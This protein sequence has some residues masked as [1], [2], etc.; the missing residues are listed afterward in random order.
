MFAEQCGELVRYL[1]TLAMDRGAS[2][3]SFVNPVTLSNLYELL[4]FWQDHYLNKD[5][6]CTALEQV[7]SQFMQF[8]LNGPLLMLFTVIKFLQTPTVL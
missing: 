2:G 5:K 7:R 8:R 6:D 4:S 3:F 1:S